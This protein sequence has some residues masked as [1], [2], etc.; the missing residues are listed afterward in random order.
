M[1]FQGFKGAVFSK[2]APFIH[3]TVL[4]EYGIFLISKSKEVFM[5]EIIFS[6]NNPKQASEILKEAIESEKL[7][8]KHSL[9]M[10]RN[11]LRKFEKKY[12]ISSEIFINQFSAEDL[13]GG[14]MEYVEWAG[15][16]RFSL[17]LLERFEALKSIKHVA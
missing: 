13:R 16:Y 7:R 12:N 14:D 1:L 6:T 17:N 9:E 15:E 8:V 2:K 5:A 4:S 10:T 11:R 3:L